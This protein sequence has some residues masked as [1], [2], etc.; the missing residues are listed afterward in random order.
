MDGKKENQSKNL[1]IVGGTMGIG[2]NTV[3]RILKKKLDN[4]VFLDGDWCW[5]M[6]PFQVTPETKKMVLGNIIFLLNSFIHCPAYENVVFCWVMHEQKIIDDILSGLD[7]AE[8]E[9][10]LFSLICSREALAERLKKDVEAGIRTE[11]VIARSME[12]LPLYGNLDT[13]K[14]DVSALTPEQTAECIME[15]ANGRAPTQ[16]WRKLWENYQSCRT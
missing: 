15:I 12:R 2:K 1:Y 14:I 4:C 8:W 13:I 3:C 10:K 11:D 7:T 16:K 9:V 5:D 6:D